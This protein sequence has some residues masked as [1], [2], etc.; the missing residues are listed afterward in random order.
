MRPGLGEQRVPGGAAGG[1]D[2]VVARPEAVREEALAAIEP[3]PFD[4]V[5]LRR[6]GIELLT[7]QPV[8]PR[9]S[10]ASAPRS[11]M[12]P[13]KRSIPVGCDVQLHNFPEQ[14]AKHMIEGL[15]KAGLSMPAQPGES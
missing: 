14:M 13:R 3:D 2:V 8:R 11:A 15:R 7:C 1:K 10:S 9:R 4:G 5:Q 6:R 12:T